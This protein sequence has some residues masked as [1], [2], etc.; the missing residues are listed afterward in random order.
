MG[1]HLLR[2]DVAERSLL[3]SG[4]GQRRS[5]RAGTGTG[6]VRGRR[7]SAKR[8]TTESASAE[9][10]TAATA[11]MTRS[12]SHFF[13]LRHVTINTMQIPARKYRCRLVGAN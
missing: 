13:A 6:S 10:R 11:G 7:A 2:S 8:I 3:L 12:V 5:A 9:M 4:A 1:M